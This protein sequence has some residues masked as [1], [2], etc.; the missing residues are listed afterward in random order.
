[1]KQNIFKGLKSFLLLWSS[2]AVSALGTSMT[3]YALIIWTYARQGTA[4]SVTLLSFSTFLPTI[5]LRFVTGAIADRWNKKRIMLAADAAAA[6]GTAVIFALYSQNALQV[7]H[8]YVTNTLLSFMDAFQSPAAHVA[9]SLLVPREQ[10][11]R[12]SGLQSLSGAC[13]VDNSAGIG[14]RAA[15]GRRAGTGAGG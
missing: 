4:S 15:G 6:C 3:S 13:R 12:V 10:Y 5:A 8:L 11:A 9:T 2:Q 1:M 14:Q 7:W